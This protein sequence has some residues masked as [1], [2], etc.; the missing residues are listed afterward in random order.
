MLERSQAQLRNPLLDI[1]IESCKTV[2]TPARDHSNTVVQCQVP[3]GMVKLR[4]V[5]ACMFYGSLAV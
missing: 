4:I 1:L 5:E 2:I 3:V